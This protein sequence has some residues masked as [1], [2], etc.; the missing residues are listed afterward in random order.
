MK[1]S[2]YMLLRFFMQFN[3]FVIFF[4]N[5]LIK[6]SYNNIVLLFPTV[7]ETS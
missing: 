2:M 6:Y 1:W 7:F 5:M 4:K 3:L